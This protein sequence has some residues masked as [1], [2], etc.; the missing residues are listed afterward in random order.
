LKDLIKQIGKFYVRRNS[1]SYIRFLRKKGCEIGERTVIFNPQNTIID[2]TRPCLISIGDDVKITDGVT[3][4]THGYDWSVLS[5]VYHEMLGS[6]G[7]V[8]IGNNVFIGMKTTILKGVTIGNNVV[9]G[10][11][12]L[13]NRDI[14]DNTVYAGNPAKFIMTIDDYYKKRLTKY[15]DEAMEL[16]VTYYERFHK[17]PPI[18][19][20]HEF[21]PTFLER[22]MNS[23]PII[24]S[25]F[26][27]RQDLIDNFNCTEPMF[28]GFHEFLKA[29]GIN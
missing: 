18:E 21:F 26:K 13:V 8:T 15:V 29:C 19:L 10:A 12:S 22:D 3:I 1:E 9:I 27:N 16:A 2:T 5:V 20:F 14:P 25:C 17:K 4:L 28:K 24:E 11:S 6:S 7:K 23:L